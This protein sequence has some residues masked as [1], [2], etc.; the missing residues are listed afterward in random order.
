MR[1][2]ISLFLKLSYD[3]TLL[4]GT[5]YLVEYHNWNPA[6]FIVTILCLVF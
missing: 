6:W 5:A 2:I 4:V 1:S 3:L